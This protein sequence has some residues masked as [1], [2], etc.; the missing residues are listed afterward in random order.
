MLYIL[1]ERPPGSISTTSRS[2]WAC[3]TAGRRRQHRARRRAPPRRHQGRRS[4]HRSGPRRGRAGRSSPGPARGDRPDPGSYTGK[5]LSRSSSRAQRPERTPVSVQ[6][7]E[8]R[9]IPMPTRLFVVARRD[10][11]PTA[12][13]GRVSDDAQVEVVLDRRVETRR[14]RA[15]R[16]AAERRRADRRGRPEIDTAPDDRPAIVG[17]PSAAATP[18]EARRWIE[19]M[20]RGV[21]A[22]GEALDDRDRLERD[23]RA[24]QQENERFAP[25]WTRRGR[26]RRDRFG[27]ARAIAVVNELRSACA[28]SPGGTPAVSRG[29]GSAGNP[30]PRHDRSRQ[31]GS[32]SRRGSRAR[33]AVSQASPGG[34]RE[35]AVQSVDS[36]QILYRRRRQTNTRAPSGRTTRAMASRRSARRSR[37]RVTAADD[38][39]YARLPGRRLDVANSVASRP[40]HPPQLYMDVM[41]GGSSTEALVGLAMGA[42]EAGCAIRRDLP[43]D[44]RLLG[45]PHRRHRR[46]RRPAGT[47]LDLAQVPYG[48][49]SAGQNFAPTFMRTCMS[50]GRPRRRSPTCGSPTASTPRKIPRVLKQRVTVQTC[51][52]GWIV[53]PL[54]LLDCCLETDNATCVIVTSAE[55]ARISS[56]GLPTSWVWPAGCR[57]RASISLGRRADSRVRGYTPRTII[58]PQAG[59]GRGRRR[60][61]LVR[62]LHVHDNAAVGGVRILQEGRRRRVRLE[63]VIELGG[64]RPNNTSGSHLWRATR[65]ACPW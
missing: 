9:E 38:D 63:R 15:L 55:R 17:A 64:K 32:I 26:A 58:F 20:Q 22:I 49:R 29:R 19:T 27:I 42:I 62:C 21:A 10:P 1:D 39:G 24:T 48:M 65:T 45:V 12:T 5:F 37:R 31:S 35:M 53:K 11:Q 56:T 34:I 23:T 40:R 13:C 18:S 16:A 3:S 46:A 47:G 25:R 36:R 2:S 54:H 14:R 28:A 44:E 4:R 7:P 59:S 6:E 33:G 43:L 57:S 50:T 30:R 51:W 61:R 52:L 8:A 60:H 41:G